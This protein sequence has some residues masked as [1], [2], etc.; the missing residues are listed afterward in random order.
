MGAEASKWLIGCLIYYFVFFMI[1]YASVNA[2]DDYDLDYSSSQAD[3][4]FST[5]ADSGLIS[6]LNASG[7][8]GTDY[9][10]NNI[11]EA[12]SL[13]FGFNTN[14]GI[15]AGQRIFFA[16]FASYLPTIIMILSIYFIF[17]P[18]KGQ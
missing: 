10:A 11:K 1:S 16:F 9:D 15:P 13:M 17:H 7:D 8:T 6:Q 5:M 14:I 12:F 4:G 2:A 3:V 18:V